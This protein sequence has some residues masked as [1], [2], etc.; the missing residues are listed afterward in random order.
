LHVVALGHI[1]TVVL[2]LLV[3]AWMQGENEG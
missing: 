2:D 3:P 1:A